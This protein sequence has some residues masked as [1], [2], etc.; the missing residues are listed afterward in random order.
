MEDLGDVESD[1]NPE[2][3]CCL[4]LFFPID[5]HEFSSNYF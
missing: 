4:H 3:F 5:F 1:Q 2:D